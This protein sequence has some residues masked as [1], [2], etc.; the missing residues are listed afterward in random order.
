MN[1]TELFCFK[2]TFQNKEITRKGIVL[3]VKIK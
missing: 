2:I 3:C 1:L